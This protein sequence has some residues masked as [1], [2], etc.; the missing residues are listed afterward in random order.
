VA[1]AVAL[2]AYPESVTRWYPLLMK[3]KDAASA[4]PETTKDAPTIWRAD[5]ALWAELQPLLVVD[6]PRKKPGRPRNDDRPLF[7]GLIWIARSGGQWQ[8]LPRAF[9]AKSTVNDRYLEWVEYGCFEKAWARLLEVYD[10]AVGLD[11][12]WQAADGCPG[13]APLGTQ[14]G[15]ARRR[16]PGPTP[17]TGG[18]AGPRGTC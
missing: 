4:A 16:R 1:T 17:P 11:W 8:A 2:T 7:D 12:Q 13:K 3:K 15:P 10:D 6:K 18:S 9:G 5:D 14:G